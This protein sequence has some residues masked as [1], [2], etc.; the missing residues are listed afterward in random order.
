VN[1]RSIRVT[2]AC[3]WAARVEGRELCKGRQR[4]GSKRLDILLRSSLTY[5]RSE[6]LNK[7][8]REISP[9]RFPFLLTQPIVLRF[10]HGRIDV[11]PLIHTSDEGRIK[12]LPECGRL[13]LLIA[14]LIWLVLWTESSIGNVAH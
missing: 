12:W 3:K 13:S 6:L 8:L 4:F 10:G 11:L 7:S 1:A 9:G 2:C 14:R 5:H